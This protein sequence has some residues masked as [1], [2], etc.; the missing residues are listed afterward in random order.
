MVSDFK[1]KLDI[2]SYAKKH[3]LFFKPAFPHLFAHSKK[4]VFNKG[5]SITF[6]YNDVPHLIFL[7]HGAVLG[8]LIF[9]D[10]QLFKVIKTPKSIFLSGKCDF[11][12]LNI[13]NQSWIVTNKAEVTAIPLTLLFH[14]LDQI[15][16]AKNKLQTHIHDII[17]VDFQCYLQFLRINPI[18]EKVDYLVERFPNYL[19]ITHKYLAE[20]LNVSQNG[21]ANA[22]KIWDKNN[23]E[24]Y[25]TIL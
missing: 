3:A 23:F 17:L 10:K 2:F 5:E 16:G 14:T 8:T 4:L 12:P 6:K 25:T 11:A 7:H 13:D 21:L 18:Q 20:Y 19:E 24:E 15:D 22:I 9:D 1:Y